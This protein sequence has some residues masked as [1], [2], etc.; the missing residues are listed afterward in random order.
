MPRSGSSQSRSK[1]PRRCGGIYHLTTHAFFKACL[2]LGSGSVIHALH[3]QSMSQMGGLRKK[4]PWTFWTFLIATLALMGF[5]PFSGFYTKDTIIAAAL[6]FAMRRPAHW[7]L[8]AFAIGAACLTAFYMARLILLTFFGKPRDRHAYEHAH[9]SGWA[10]VLPLVVL[11]ALSLPPMGGPHGNWFWFRNPTPTRAQIEQ[12]YGPV[13][14]LSVGEEQ[15][16]MG[17]GAGH[18]EEHLAAEASLV[19]LGSSHEEAQSEGHGGE[20]AVD[21]LAH[22]AHLVAVGSSVGAFAVGVLLALLTY[23]FGVIRPEKVAQ[24]FGPLYRLLLNKYYVD[25][26]YMAAVIRP[27]LRLCRFIG[28][29]DNRVIDGAVNLT[30]SLTRWVSALVGMAD[31]DVVD[32]TVNAVG[33]AAMNTGRVLSR[34]QSGRVG[35]YLAG[36]FVGMVFLAGFVFWILGRWS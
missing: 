29:F 16:A 14:E 9:E 36:A 13:G 25:E 30:G 12:R 5:W 15:R 10:M 23:G 31:R 28:G 32:G 18:A 21:A 22:K 33:E 7:L 4:T 3:T 34:L 24:R 2:F 8:P 11:A 35:S 17:A 1:F 27:F 6:E 26:F 20:H 19:T